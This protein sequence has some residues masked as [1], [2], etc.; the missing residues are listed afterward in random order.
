M[1]FIQFAQELVDGIHANDVDTRVE[2]DATAGAGKHEGSM[3]RSLQA[4]PVIGA[5]V[6]PVGRR[7]VDISLFRPPF[8]FQFK[9]EESLAGQEDD[10]GSTQ[11]IWQLVLEERGVRP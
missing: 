3:H 8:P 5:Q 7:L 4:L 6:A 1:R 9:D 10:V 2:A 11:L